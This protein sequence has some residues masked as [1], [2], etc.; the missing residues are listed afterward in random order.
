MPITSG[1]REAEKAGMRRRTKTKIGR[2]EEIRIENK[3]DIQRNLK[4]S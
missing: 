4:R 1:D 3:G 2:K